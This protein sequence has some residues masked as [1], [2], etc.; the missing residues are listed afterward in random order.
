MRMQSYSSQRNITAVWI[1]LDFFWQTAWEPTTSPGIWVWKFWFFPRRHGSQD[2]FY[3]PP[4]LSCL[5]PTIS[6]WKEDAHSYLQRQTANLVS[7]QTWSGK[8]KAC[9]TIVAFQNL[10]PMR[11]IF[12]PGG[13]NAHPP[14]GSQC[15]IITHQFQNVNAD[16]NHEISDCRI[17]FGG[18]PKSLKFWWLEIE[19]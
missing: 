6:K 9:K 1:I 17:F 19:P 2:N 16:Q 18:K 15:R 10:F 8:S 13:G 14:F 11:V 3:L 5:T 12:D 4:P 7:F